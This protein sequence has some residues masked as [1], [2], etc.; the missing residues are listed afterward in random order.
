MRERAIA[1]NLHTTGLRW[2]EPRS[3]R[4][5][6]ESGFYGIAV[7]D[8]YLCIG[9]RFGQAFCQKDGFFLVT[10]N[11]VR[12]HEAFFE[13]MPCLIVPPDHMVNPPFGH[14]QSSSSRNLH[15][16]ENPAIRAVPEN[17]LGNSQEL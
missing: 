14:K 9:K 8:N 11:K 5:I 1:E 13:Y 15:G 10:S 6:S 17:G 16:A 12:A 2:S 3:I 4:V 7:V